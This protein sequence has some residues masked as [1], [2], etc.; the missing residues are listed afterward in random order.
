M[1]Q[2]AFTT[3]LITFKSLKKYILEFFLIGANAQRLILNLTGE[4]P[5]YRDK[6]RDMKAAWI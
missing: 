3:F 4:L 5:F 2:Y 1:E 6:G